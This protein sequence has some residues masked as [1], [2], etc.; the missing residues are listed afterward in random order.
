[1]NYTREDL[2]KDIADNIYRDC[3]E[4]TYTEETVKSL[5]IDRLRH[6]SNIVA[7]DDI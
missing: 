3:N 5:I 2:L 7:S 4:H 1:M 6:M